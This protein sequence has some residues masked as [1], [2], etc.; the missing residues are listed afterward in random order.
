MRKGVSRKHFVT[1][2]AA[3]TFASIGFVRYPADAAQF[4]YKFAH[5]QPESSPV[6]LRAKELWDRVRAQ[7]KGRLNVTIYPNSQL[8]GDAAMVTQLRSG[9]IQFHN[10]SGL[11]IGSVVPEASIS[12]LPFAFKTSQEVYRAFDGELGALVRAKLDAAGLYA[13]PNSML[14]NGFRQITA[15]NHPIHTVDDLVGFKI[16]TPQGALWVDLFKALGANVATI[17]IAEVYTALQT[18]VVDGEENSYYIIDFF[19]FQEVQKYLSVTNHMYDGWWVLANGDAWK[20]LPPEVQ[21]IVSRNVVQYARDERRDIIAL[22]ER[23]AEKL[24]AAGMIFNV[25]DTTAFRVKIK[26]VY[27]KYRALYGEQMWA[28]LEKVTG[29]LG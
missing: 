26:P 21:S 2:G 22:N 7:T 27:A 18:H 1:T 16:R 19:R 14:E 23:L 8:G 25:A 12:G 6:H 3:A 4:E 20:A 17:S 28:A 11:I 24:K 10:Q 15:S 29:P 13:F 5:N 9:A